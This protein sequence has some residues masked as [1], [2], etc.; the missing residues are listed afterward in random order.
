MITCKYLHTYFLMIIFNCFV[1]QCYTLLFNHD[2]L[3]Q[4]ATTVLYKF[5][6]SIRCKNACNS[7]NGYA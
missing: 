7:K 1:E 6:N 2:H 3:Y 5:D 4:K